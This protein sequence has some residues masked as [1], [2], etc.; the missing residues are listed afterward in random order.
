[1]I[2]LYT[3]KS[4]GPIVEKVILMLN[5]TRLEYISVEIDMSSDIEGINNLSSLN[6]NKTVPVIKD[7]DTGV[8]VYESNAIL[9]YLAEKENMLLPVSG[10]NRINIL[11]WLMFESANF[12][13]VMGELYYYLLK[14]PSELSN[15]HI[16]RYEEKMSSYCLM[17]ENQLTGREYLCDE[18][19]IADIT[20][21]PWTVILEDLANID[22]NNYLQLKEWIERVKTRVE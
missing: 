11:N 18:F 4:G 3:N 17:L 14:S 21:Y 22:L 5:E 10:A 13:A 1:M 19:S 20:Y 7:D 9:I 6:P 2:T 8:V 15:H 12:G 16:K